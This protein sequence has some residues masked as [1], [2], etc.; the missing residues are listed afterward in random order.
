MGPLPFTL[1]EL[2]Y[3]NK[4]FDSALMASFLGMKGQDLDESHWW[5][6]YKD[7]ADMV[8]PTASF[9]KVLACNGRFEDVTDELTEI[10][11]GSMTGEKIYGHARAYAVGS[12]MSK[13]INDALAKLGKKAKIS[14]KELGDF[15]DAALREAANLSTSSALNMKRT[16]IVKYA[17]LEVKV[18]VVSFPEEPIGI[19][20]RILTSVLAHVRGNVGL[21]TFSSHHAW[22][23]V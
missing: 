3:L 7:V 9:E 11:S 5:S 16:I 4:H 19:L 8:L 18:V 13:F 20:E 14:A 6:V 2:A 21:P 12:A 1:Q 23:Y 22:C 17:G 10:V 15:T